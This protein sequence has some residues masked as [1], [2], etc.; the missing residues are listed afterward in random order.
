LLTPPV[1]TSQL[2]SESQQPPIVRV[3]KNHAQQVLCHR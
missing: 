1:E 2:S 3:G